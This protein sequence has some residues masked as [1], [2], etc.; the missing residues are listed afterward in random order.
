MPGIRENLEKIRERIARAAELSGRQPSSVKLLAV[1][2]TF[3][4]EDV[5]EAIRCGQ[6]DFGENRVQELE[7]KAPQFS[8][9]ND[10][11]VWHLIG[12]LQTNKAAKAAA[13]ADWIHSVDSV[14]VLEKIDR[15]AERDI[16][17][18]LELNL[19]GEEAK[20]GMSGGYEALRSLVEAA[21]Q[22]KHLK[23]TGLMTMAA[24]GADEKL[25]R[26]T[27]ASLRELRDRAEREYGILLPELSMGMSADFEHAIREGST[28]VRIGTAI[29]GGRDYGP[30]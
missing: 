1:S 21:L 15:S 11:P 24:L 10:M 20:T 27:F 12:H 6:R 9:C 30:R 8:A 16:R 14:R 28:I 22:A 5:A 7:A 13:L 2:K 29:F 26:S 19:S 3:P 17:I 4:A 18:L 23:L 25:A